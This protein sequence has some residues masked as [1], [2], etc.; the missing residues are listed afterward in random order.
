MRQA[1]F[2]FVISTCILAASAL[3][4]QVVPT[5]ASSTAP[6]SS[7]LQVTTVGTAVSGSSNLASIVLTGTVVRDPMVPGRSAEPI[8]LQVDADGKTQMKISATSGTISEVRVAAGHLSS[9]TST[10]DTDKPA[11]TASNCWSAASWV[12]PTLALANNTVAAKLSTASATI[13]KGG[14]SLLQMSLHIDAAGHSPG[15]MRYIS[16]VSARTVYLDPQTLLPLSMTY[17]EHP[18]NNTFV[19]MPVE[20]DYSNYQTVGGVTVPFHIVKKLNDAP[21]LDI[22]LRQV[23]VNH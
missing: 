22:T 4:G 13:T 7:V 12:L 9:C 11:I 10:G 23:T 15:G 14:S 16:A 8:W 1:S 17:S 19:N 18:G 3:R 5:L 21:I 6:S 2:G 20:V